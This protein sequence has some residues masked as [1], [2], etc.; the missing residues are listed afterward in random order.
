MSSSPNVDQPVPPASRRARRVAFGFVAL[1]LVVAALDRVVSATPP[2]RSAAVRFAEDELRRELVRNR[3]QLSEVRPR[4]LELRLPAPALVGRGLAA[5]GAPVDSATV[6]GIARRV[7][8][9]YAPDR[10]RA[11]AGVDTVIVVLQGESG[12]LGLVGGSEARVFAFDAAT[13]RLPRLEP[14]PL[15]VR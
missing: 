1:A 11:Q 5:D 6:Q 12:W 3:L 8:E 13:L 9:V 14:A 10:T 2:T 15:P 7:L 4:T